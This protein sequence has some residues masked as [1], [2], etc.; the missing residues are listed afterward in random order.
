MTS[1]VS[2]TDAVSVSALNPGRRLRSTT[3]LPLNCTDPIVSTGLGLGAPMATRKKGPA[4]TSSV[5]LPYVACAA[6]GAV[7]SSTLTVSV[8]PRVM[9]E[10]LGNVI[11]VPRLPTERRA[12]TPAGVTST[13]P[14]RWL[15]GVKLTTLPRERVA[16]VMLISRA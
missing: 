9:P 5:V 1:A 4:G 13:S 11:A 15:P 16:S 7:F 14:C 6:V 3:T 8:V 2:P 10:L 12:A